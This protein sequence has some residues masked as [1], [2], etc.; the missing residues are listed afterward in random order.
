MGRNAVPMREIAGMACLFGEPRRPSHSETRWRRN[1]QLVP[2]DLL[3]G[4]GNH[5]LPEVGEED[6]LRAFTSSSTAWMA[7]IGRSVADILSWLPPCS[8]AEGDPFSSGWC[9]LS[10]AM[11]T[12]KSRK[13]ATSL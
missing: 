4:G 6:C 2:Q 10:F 13:V 7:L 8:V 9:S 3:Y 1:R 5:S 12:E 11:R